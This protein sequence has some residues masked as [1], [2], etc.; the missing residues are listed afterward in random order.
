MKK[1]DRITAIVI[2]VFSALVIFESG[3]MPQMVEFAPGYG[4]FPFWLG[5]IMAV[6]SILL[7]VESYR[8][9]AE[10]D[11]PQPFPARK[12]M[13]AVVAM[14]VILVVYVATL[15]ILGYVI[16]T[17]AA[18][19]AMLILL[20]REPWKKAAIFAVAFTA[21]LYVVFH[22]ALGIPVPTNILGF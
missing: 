15:E 12:A 6:L 22:V 9:P 14:L 13:L 2:L 19:L 21:G 4:F 10:E 17:I 8:R 1:T 11:E 3:K 16:G 7:F 18:V 5:V 20:E